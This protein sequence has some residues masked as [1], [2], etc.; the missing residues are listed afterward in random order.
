MG[1]RNSGAAWSCTWL[2]SR[3]CTDLFPAALPSGDAAASL[4]TCLILLCLT[5]FPSPEV[6]HVHLHQ[7]LTTLVLS[8]MLDL[9][10]SIPVAAYS[11]L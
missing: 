5:T 1:Q 2:P 3:E 4:V 7:V 11:T 9:H 6:V 8:A 10:L